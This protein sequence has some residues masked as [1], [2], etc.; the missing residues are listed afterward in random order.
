MTKDELTQMQAETLAF[1]RSYILKHGYSPTVAE[2]AKAT[3]VNGNAI[4]GRLTALIQKARLPRHLVLREVLDPGN[5]DLNRTVVVEIFGFQF[6][7]QRSYM[8]IQVYR[9]Y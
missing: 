2:M 8:Q 4:S 9:K 6:K 5:P 3:D 7:L 1:I